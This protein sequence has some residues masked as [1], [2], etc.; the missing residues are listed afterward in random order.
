MIFLHVYSS[1]AVKINAALLITEFLKKPNV[2]T[3]FDTCRLQ[4]KL[5]MAIQECIVQI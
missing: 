5:L 2:K 1:K 4:I 3:L